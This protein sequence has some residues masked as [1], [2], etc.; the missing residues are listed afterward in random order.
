MSF[1]DSHTLNPEKLRSTEGVGLDTKRLFSAAN[2]FRFLT[3]SS[4]SRRAQR[5]LK[6][7][8]PSWACLRRIRR[9]CG[10]L[11]RKGLIAKRLFSAA[12]SVTP[13]FELKFEESA[14]GTQT[15]LTW[16]GLSEANPE[17]LRRSEAKKVC[18]KS[19]VLCGKS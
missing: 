7:F 3:L 12:N 11:R 5:V 18:R 13:H 8:S 16:L 15:F 10:G 2:S 6:P 4:N 1:R 9:N 19:A 17:K 14:K